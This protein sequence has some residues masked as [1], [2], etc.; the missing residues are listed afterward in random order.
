MSSLDIR[1]RNTSLYYFSSRR[2]SSPICSVSA[3]ASKVPPKHN[4]WNTV[5]RIHLKLYQ[6]DKKDTMSIGHI[7]TA[8]CQQHCH[9][10]TLSPR[11]IV[12]KTLLG[13]HARDHGMNSLSFLFIFKSPYLLYVLYL[14]W[15]FWLL[16]AE[17]I[18]S[19][20]QTSLTEK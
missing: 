17:L 4:T 11:H 13:H 5:T 1:L 15:Q 20:F 2:A 19:I 12:N 7:D 9:H 18:R 8:C 14:F 6:K 3:H 10:D 16:N